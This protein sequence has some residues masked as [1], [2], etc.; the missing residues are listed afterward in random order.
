MK[1]NLNIISRFKNIDSDKLDISTI[2]ESL[3]KGLFNTMLES[4]DQQSSDPS[5]SKYEAKDI[6]KIIES[7]ARKNMIL[8]AASSIVPGPFGILGSVPELLLNFKNQ[9]SM[10]YDLGCANGKE[11]FINKD[12]LLDIPFSAFG[13][14]TNLS[15]TQNNTNLEDSAE[16]ILLNKSIA[17][18]ENII[19]RT[20]KKSIIQFVPIGGPILMGT[21][22]KMTTSKVSKKSISFLDDQQ[23]FIEHVKPEESE[24]VKV[25]IQKEKVKSLVNLIESN[26]DINEDQIELI[27]TI[28]ENSI[29]SEEEKEFFLNES[30]K[31][32]SKFELDKSMIKLYEEEED[33]L[34]QLVVMAK[35]SGSIDE[36]EKKYIFEVA[37]TLGIDNQSVSQLF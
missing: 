16:T 14:N 13:G 3:S 29:L 9:M 31:P 24:E 35:R 36:L 28:I 12:V 11:N 32:G 4:Y 7:Y 26:N 27:G 23:T 37:S 20:L 30:I 1:F 19:D 34:L 18:S 8:A 15:L 2:K 5:N 21:W 17:L 25:L 33:L 10:I 22:A 6:D